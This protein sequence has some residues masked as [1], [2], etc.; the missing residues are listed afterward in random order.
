MAKI[1]VEFDTVEKSLVVTMDG[2]KVKNVSEVEF[3]A[4]D[5]GMGFVELKTFEFME[6]EKV[7]KITKIMAEDE[8]PSDNETL[9]DETT[10]DVDEPTEEETIE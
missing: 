2:K 4:F 8:T 1:V 7:V 3:M 10:S 6:E 9:S 5:E